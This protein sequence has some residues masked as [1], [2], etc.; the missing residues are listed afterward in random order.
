[1]A[2]SAKR[3]ESGFIGV[4]T[5]APIG[6]VGG[7]REFARFEGNAD[8]E[9]ALMQIYGQSPERRIKGAEAIM[10][11]MSKEPIDPKMAERVFYPLL[12]LA[13][14]ERDKAVKRSFIKALGSIPAQFTMP[15]NTIQ[16]LEELAL[17]ETDANV[18]REAAR[19][20]FRLS[21]DNPTAPENV[22]RLNDKAKRRFGDNH[23]V[24]VAILDVMVEL[25]K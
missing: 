8:L 14:S 3:T 20:I 7:R 24:R 13:E 22:L 1:M 10:M 23:I 11:L 9:E 6:S 21:N 2:K 12:T 25:C 18:V 16:R 15:A 19:A 5:Q 4:K 17:K